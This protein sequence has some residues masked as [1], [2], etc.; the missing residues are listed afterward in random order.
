M[1][2]ARV[3]AEV[4]RILDAEARRLLADQLDG[5]ALG[6]PTPGRDQHAVD[7]RADQGTA[8]VKGKPVPIPGR[9]ERDDGAVAA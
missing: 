4:Q 1:L 7:G 2:P 3:Q 8:S 9:V 5:D 6:A